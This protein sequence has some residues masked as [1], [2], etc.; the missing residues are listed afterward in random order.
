MNKKLLLVSSLAMLGMLSACGH[1]ESSDSGSASSDSSPSSSEAKHN[2]SDT[3]TYDEEYHWKKCVVSGHTDVSEKAK[4]N[5]DEGTETKA[6]TETETGVKTYTCLTCSYM[7]EEILPMIEHVHT[8]DTENW[9]QNET[10]HWHKATCVHTDEKDSYA[11]HNFSTEPVVDTPATYT[12]NGSQHYTC[13]TCSYE[14]SETIPM[15]EKKD[16]PITLLI[17]Q[18]QLKGTYDGRK[19]SAFINADS[20]SCQNGAVTVAYQKE[21]DSTWYGAADAPKNAGTYKIKAAISEGEDFKAN[22]MQVT[23]VIEQRV[24][25]AGLNLDKVYDGSSTK[26]ISNVKDEKTDVLVK[27]GAVDGDD[28]NVD[29]DYGYSYVTAS[30]SLSKGNI[31]LS[32]DD[33]ANYKLALDKDTYTISTKRTLTLPSSAK[34]GKFTRSAL[35]RRHNLIYRFTE[36]DG[37]LP[38]DDVYLYDD[39]QQG[40]KEMLQIGT[41]EF[42]SK[43]LFLS[44]GNYTYEKPEEWDGM[45]LTLEVLN[46]ETF[47]LIQTAEISNTHTEVISTGYIQAGQ[48]AVGDT[49]YFSHIV[50]PAQVEKIEDSSGNSID[51]AGRF[52]YDSVKLYLTSPDSSDIKELFNSVYGGAGLSVWGDAESAKSIPQFDVTLK[53][54]STTTEYKIGNMPRL[55]F[56]PDLL[57][58]YASGNNSFVDLSGKGMQVSNAKIIEIRGSDNKPVSSIPTGEERKVT[59][60]FDPNNAYP[61][62]VGDEF[63][64]FLAAS[65]GKAA[66]VGKVTSVHTHLDGY[67]KTGYCNEELDGGCGYMVTHGTFAMSADEKTYTFSASEGTGATSINTGQYGFYEITLPEGKFFEFNIVNSDGEDITDKNYHAMYNQDGTECQKKKKVVRELSGKQTIYTGYTGPDS[68]IVTIHPDIPLYNFQMTFTQVYPVS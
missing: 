4:H 24:L 59:F 52:E 62:Q 68:F 35:E 13:L 42:S 39:D 6:A 63:V 37:V 47:R 46:D 48:V 27:Y 21:G 32:G 7:K 40:G 33:A 19:I 29:V 25:G 61:M 10:H 28:V 53:N 55:Y 56:V 66:L 11:E 36:E 51:R 49:V 67:Y 14:K 17:S 16:S 23:F 65:S 44:T 1:Q 57:F 12:A 26:T 18:D 54:L 20:F 15:L 2:Y 64:S 58:T 3:Y 34:S 22:E 43:Y 38:G 8:F 60:E 45:T 30:A 31:T 41:H 50:K 5:F 9:E